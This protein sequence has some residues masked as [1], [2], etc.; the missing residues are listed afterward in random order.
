MRNE[1]DAKNSP[2]KA[3]RKEVTSKYPTWAT[4]D[5]AYIKLP[6]LICADKRL[7]AHDKVGRYKVTV[8]IDYAVINALAR[9]ELIT[10]ES[11]R[12]DPSS[13]FQVS[14]RRIAQMCGMSE[15]NR[16]AIQ[17]S[18]DRLEDFGYLLRSKGGGGMNHFRLCM[19]Q[20]KTVEELVENYRI[21]SW[22]LWVT[23]FEDCIDDEQRSE[24]ERYFKIA[25]RLL[26]Q[27]KDKC[28]QRSR[29]IPYDE[30]QSNAYEEWKR[31]RP[32]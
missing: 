1:V 15:K 29:P 11:R 32:E 21:L 17:D 22:H 16:K 18:F 25:G 6:I 24:F 5:E 23:A 31:N 3:K 30:I 27:R 12:G 4:Q 20:I 7:T 28:K 9:I 10:R 19:P 26:R 13:P 8:G 2:R 14:R